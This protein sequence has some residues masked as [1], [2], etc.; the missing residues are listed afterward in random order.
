MIDVKFKLLS[1]Q[2]NGFHILVNVV[3]F[4]KKFKAVIDT[5]ASRTVLDKSTVEKYISADMLNMSDQLSTGLGTNSMESHTLNIQ[6][7]NIGD[8]EIVDIDVAVLDLSTINAAFEQ[9]S[10]KP[11]V[12][13]IGG[14]ILVNYKAIINYPMKKISF[15]K[16]QKHTSRKSKASIK[17]TL[18][19]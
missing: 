15:S 17:K 7:M 3:V 13:V 4:G 1:F 6:K 18:P 8:L 5:G 9:V 10:V 16:T 11:V 14:D 12:G 19:Y 2:D